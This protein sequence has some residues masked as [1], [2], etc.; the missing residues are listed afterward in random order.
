M[1]SALQ[2]AHRLP[3]RNL[4]A[5]GNALSI[6]SAARG[7]LASLPTLPGR[8]SLFLMMLYVNSYCGRVLAQAPAGPRDR[9]AAGGDHGMMRR[10]VYI[11]P[12]GLIHTGAVRLET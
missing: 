5:C 2:E 7:L 1:L 11:G 4:Q 9:R 3:S 6:S 10:I 8:G 12:E